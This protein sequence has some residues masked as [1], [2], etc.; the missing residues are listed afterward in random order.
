[1]HWLLILVTS[2]EVM[3]PPLYRWHGSL[4]R[5]VGAFCIIWA[6]YVVL[7]SDMGVTY[8]F[9]SPHL[10][11]SCL[12][13]PSA[14][15]GPI[16]FGVHY[17]PA[18]TGIYV[19]P[20]ALCVCSFQGLQ[21]NHVTCGFHPSS[22]DAPVEVHGR[23]CNFP[24]FHPR[25]ALLVGHWV[26]ALPLSSF[27]ILPFSPLT[28]VVLHGVGLVHLSNVWQ[29]PI[30]KGMPISDMMGRSWFWCR[31]RW[32]SVL[33]CHFVRGDISHNLMYHLPSLF[34]PPILD[35]PLSFQA[36]AFTSI[37]SQGCK[38]TAPIFLS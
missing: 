29:L 4:L 28:E 15:I 9:H 20:S 32:P 10:V 16:P 38:F 27:G 17:L 36:S 6:D 35:L 37:R 12:P 25:E 2:L 13:L 1:M 30:H 8:P 7:L 14:V 24:F 23:S 22:V 5:W 18:S 19:I 33:V 11:W 3:M 26:T 31:T 34:F 21:P